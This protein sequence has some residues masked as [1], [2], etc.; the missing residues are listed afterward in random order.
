MSYAYKVNSLVKSSAAIGVK[1]VANTLCQYNAEVKLNSDER[2]ENSTYDTMI[3]MYMHCLLKYN[4]VYRCII[5]LYYYNDT[6]K[7]HT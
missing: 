2:N 3:Q 1:F 5:D 4:V 6:Y 7:M